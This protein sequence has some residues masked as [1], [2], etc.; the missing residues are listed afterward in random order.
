MPDRK[1]TMT[2]EFMMLSK[3]TKGKVVLTKRHKYK[4]IFN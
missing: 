3:H 2:K 4:E 1:R